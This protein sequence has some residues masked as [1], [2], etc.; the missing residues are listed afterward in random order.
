MM[1]AIYKV[2]KWERSSKTFKFAV[3][4][5]FVLGVMFPTLAITAAKVQASQLVDTTAGVTTTYM[6]GSGTWILLGPIVCELL[7]LIGIGKVWE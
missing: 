3:F 1:R 5:K 7:T 6:L 2:A 4:L